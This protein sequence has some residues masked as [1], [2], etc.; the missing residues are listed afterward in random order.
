[1]NNPAT[2]HGR[3]TPRIRRSRR[4]WGQAA[5]LALA[6][7]ACT[8]AGAGQAQ[9]RYD[10]LDHAV[11]SIIRDIVEDGA[12][13]GQSVFVGADDF[14]ETETEF[15]LRP[16]LSE[17]L[18]AK[19]RTALTRNGVNPG[20]VESDEAWVLHGRWWRETRDSREY[21]HLR[22]FIARPVE[23]DTPPQEHEGEAG[24]IPIDGDIENAV[25]PTLR[26]WGDSVVRQLERDLPGT[27]SYRL[28]IRPFEVEGVVAQPERLDR[29]LRNRWRRAFTGSR[30]FGL[31]GST[32]FD[33]ELFGEVSVTDE[34]VEVDLYVEDTQG[35]KVASALAKPDKGLFPSGVVGTGD[36]CASHARAK[37]PA[38]AVECYA[39]MLK[40]ASGDRKA[41]EGLEGLK[42]E[43]FRDC[44]E[45]PELVV[46]PSGSFMMGSPSGE[47]GRGANEGPVH[48]VAIGYPFAVGVYE[49]T[50]REW[51]ACVS[52]G[53]CG[54][55]RPSD[56]DWGRGRQPVIHVSWNDAKAYVEWLSVKTGQG[57]R[58]LSEAEWEY[59]ARGGTETARYWG[60][61]ETGQCRY[62]NGADNASG[63]PDK[64]KASC[65]DDY[66]NTSPVGSFDPNDFGLHD[67][68]GNVWERVEDCSNDSYSGAPTD[69]SAWESGNCDERVLRGGSLSDPPGS[70]RSAGRHGFSTRERP[71]NVGFRV[72]RTLTP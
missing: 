53:G 44:P 54:G 61:S 17:M 11:S 56:E 26:H 32:G 24:L 13:R 72:A 68:L 27:G 21:L 29:H 39:G 30:R 33:G 7:L 35:E 46:V 45:C 28:H 43:V 64:E 6:V 12:L 52:A 38:E 23:G 71:P 42:G 8:F 69:G 55:Y 31:V 67:V 66:K 58:L 47:A 16:R 22:L 70:L 2:D 49:V 63:D 34:H 4:G 5:R 18:R 51:D 37:R 65:N 25:K 41:L 36:E 15:R 62:A 20:M 10:H 50:F 9:E 60:E 57:Y 48:R 14:F 1:M 59:V 19:S 40:E 3:P